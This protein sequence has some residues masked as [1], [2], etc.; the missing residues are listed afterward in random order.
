MAI[1]FGFYGQDLCQVV[2]ERSGKTLIINDDLILDENEIWIRD[3]AKDLEG[4]LVFGD[5]EGP[6]QH[7][8]KLQYYTGWSVI[9][10]NGHNFDPETDPKEWN[11][12][13]KLQIHSE[14]GTVDLRD[15][16][17]NDL[18]Y[19]IRL[20]KL[21]RGSSG[22]ELIKLAIK[23]EKEEK[24]KSYIWTSQ[25]ASMIG[26]NLGWGQ[27]GLTLE[28]STPHFGFD[29]PPVDYVQKFVDYIEGHFDSGAQA[30]EDKDYFN[31]HLQMCTVDASELG[32][33]VLYVEQAVV[34]S[35]E[36]PYR[37]RLY[38]VESAGDA[39]I[40]SNI[41]ELNEPEKF[42]GG[43]SKKERPQLWLQMPK[44]RLVVMLI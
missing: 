24:T 29:T 18:G 40:R 20:A 8:R 17:G 11:S 26:M 10:P 4:K 19:T 3:V 6:H 2:S 14:G 34:T 28:E 23:D 13:L 22:T 35:L 31:I 37:Q 30:E 27:V 33:H 42:V 36:A 25:D 43:C 44:R 21:T 12:H 1:D 9:R 7:N 15:A 41:Y 32:E 39:Q 16:E 5:P 38:V